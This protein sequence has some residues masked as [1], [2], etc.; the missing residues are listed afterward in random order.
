MEHEVIFDHAAQSVIKITLPGLYGNTLRL[1]NGAVKLGPATPLEYLDRWALSN[2]LFE[3]EA[4]V[5]GLV[6]DPAGPRLAMAQPLV[7]GERPQ[8]GEVE[9]FMKRLGF[10]RVRDSHLFLHFDRELLVGDAHP[11]NFLRNAEGHI[12]A[13]DVLPVKA[14]GPLLA[15]A[16][17][18]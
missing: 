18:F 9:D 12:F 5:L 6:N 14:S 10:R 2:E 8:P 13:I 1:K 17:G 16:L 7:V 15:Y 3:D 4:A 11:G